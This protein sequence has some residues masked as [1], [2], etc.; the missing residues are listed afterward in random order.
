MSFLGG[1]PSPTHDTSTG[2]PARSGPMSL[3]GGYPGQVRRCGIPARTG[4]GTHTHTHKHTLSRAQVSICRSRCASCSFP[5]EGFLFGFFFNGHK[6]C[7]SNLSE[8][9]LFLAV[10]IWQEIKNYA[11]T[12]KNFIVF[13]ELF[14]WKSESF[15]FIITAINLSSSCII[16]HFLPKHG[17]KRFRLR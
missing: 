6:L 3:P 17:Q 10:R 4:W 5:H 1:S 7:L 15:S 12:W 8:N 11:E 9:V 16:Y 2:F 13:P 14:L